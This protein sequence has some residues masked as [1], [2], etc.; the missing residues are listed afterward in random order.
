MQHAEQRQVNIMP[1]YKVIID[2]GTTDK[3]RIDVK[4]TTKCL[5]MSHHSTWT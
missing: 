2:T 4:N 3:Q 1:P 5:N